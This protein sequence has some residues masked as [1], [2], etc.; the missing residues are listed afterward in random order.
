MA[1]HLRG[2]RTRVGVLAGA[3][4]AALLALP[5][6]ASAAVTS[7]VAGGVLTVNSTADDAITITCAID[8]PLP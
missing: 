2:T 4:A 1:R 8:G 5:G 3:A 6:V 7:T